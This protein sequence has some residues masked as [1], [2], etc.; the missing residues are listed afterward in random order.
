MKGHIHID[1]ELCKGCSL[2]IE[3]C[4][5]CSIVIAKK[6]NIK[7]YYPADFVDKK[8]CTGCA[9]CAVM[10]PEAAIEVYRDEKADERK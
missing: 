6:L 1:Q 3:F 7:G 8:E 9:T 10:C 4:P 2:C 5:R